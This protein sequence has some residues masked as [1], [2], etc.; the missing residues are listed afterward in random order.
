MSAI[1]TPSPNGAN[2][3]GR[4]A[5]GRFVKGN[6]GGPGNPHA[7]AAGAWRSALTRVV[8]PS[9]VEA[10]LAVLVKRA[11]AGEPWA[12][13]ELLDRCLGKVRQSDVEVDGGDGMELRVNV[14][15]GKMLARQM[16][17]LTSLPPAPGL[18][19]LPPWKP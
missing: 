5:C 18:R 15:L 8:L 11:K 6:R 3:D 4:D 1:E 16:T 10:V 19:P 7:K 14:D 9:D 13:R 17:D 2:G 12:V